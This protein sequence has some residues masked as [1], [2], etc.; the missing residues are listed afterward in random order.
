MARATRDARF[1][2]PT[3][4]AAL[5]KRKK[6]Y[7]R[8]IEPG[9]HLG[10]YAGVK[11][12]SWV[13]RRY[14]GGGAYKTQAVA[15]ADDGRE[16]DGATVMTWAQAQSA[17]RAWATAED[18]R[19]AGF[20][21]PEPLT[22]RKA[23]EN[24]LAD[25]TGR[26]GRALAYVSGT[27]DAHVLP[28]LGDVLVTKLTTDILRRWHHAL[29]AAPVRRRQGVASV[30]AE[31]KG[32][33][34]VKLSPEAQRARRATANAVLTL[35]KAA[36]NLAYRD[37]GV[38]SDDAWR[39]VQPFKQVDAPRIRYLLDDEVT[40]LVNVCP[41][42]FREIVIAALLTGCR[43]G[44]LCAMKAGDFDPRAGGVAI[45]QSKSGKA[46]HVALT[47]EGRAFFARHA[48]GKPGTALLFERDSQ[49]KQ[50]TRDAPAK[51]KRGAWGKSHQHRVLQEA[52]KAA[53]IS[54]AISFHILRHTYASRLARHGAPMKV[55]A[56]QLGHADTKL[57]ERHY[58]HLSGSHVAEVVRETFS[59]MGIGG[60]SGTVTPIRGVQK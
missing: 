52:C 16:A 60:A 14:S 46:R 43:Y 55:I 47:D 6:P 10:Y 23:I 27:F 19:A 38:P 1:D 56:E 36:L 21:P 9:L 57:T 13:A 26:G 35:F 20:A 33:S 42:D 37:E 58:A 39:R 15:V 31:G 44:E 49:V 4:R 48:M 29:A 40:R 51:T 5:A 53:S 3:A 22:M 7:F 28:K 25:Y 12:G 18:R 2:T 17:A 54:P 11:G 59:D 45:H 32:A 8:L 30:Q 24:Y 34:K 50:A 41:P